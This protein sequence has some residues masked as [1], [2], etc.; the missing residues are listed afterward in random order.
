MKVVEAPITVIREEERPGM[1]VLMGGYRLTLTIDEARALVATVGTALEDLS[2][3]PKDS[4]GTP[5]GGADPLA[6]AAKV[7]EQVI[8]WAKI[9]SG[10]EQR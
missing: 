2:P 4:A 5:A 1:T 3:A 6:I 9:A 7:K 10:I 8:S